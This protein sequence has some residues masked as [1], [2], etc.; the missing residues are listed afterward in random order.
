[1]GGPNAKSTRPYRSKRGF[2]T[3]VRSLRRSN[4]IWHTSEFSSEFELSA[5]L[6]QEQREQG[7]RTPRSGVEASSFRDVSDAA[8]RSPIRP[9]SPRIPSRVQND[10]RLGA[11]QAP[12][13][14][15]LH[16]LTLPQGRSSSPGGIG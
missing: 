2:R 12:V 7:S 1:M 16:H 10:R 8:K 13:R 6:E 11:A 15:G 4:G 5:S 14:W 3:L 9:S